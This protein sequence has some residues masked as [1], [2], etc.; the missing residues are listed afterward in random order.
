MERNFDAGTIRRLKATA[1]N[2][3]TIG[4]A[5]LAAQALGADLVDELQLFAVP[6]IVGGG[7]RWLPDGL[8]LDLELLDSRQFLTGTVFVRYHVRV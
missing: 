5:D 6:V 2:D 3:L 7:K 1:T 8:R 4:G